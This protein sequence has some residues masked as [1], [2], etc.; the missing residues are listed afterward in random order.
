MFSDFDMCA[1]GTHMPMCTILFC[2]AV[3]GIF[4]SLGQGL[5]EALLCLCS[6]PAR[7]KSPWGPGA[8]CTKILPRI[9][10]P[11]PSLTCA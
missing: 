7:P 1:V 4:R 5:A 8:A 6:Y 3:P 10:Q 9:C 11:H 2:L